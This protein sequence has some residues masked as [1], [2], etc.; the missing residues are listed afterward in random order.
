MKTKIVIAGNYRQY[1]HYLR[2]N[3]L[4]P[5]DARY[6]C[7][8]EQLRGLRKVEIVRYGTWWENPCAFDD[9]LLILGAPNNGVQPI[10]YGG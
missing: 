2:E 5:R 1:L 8:V 10:E 3:E 9:Y 7:E 6:C 4:S